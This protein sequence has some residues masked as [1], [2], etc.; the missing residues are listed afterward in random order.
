MWLKSAGVDQALRYWIEG[1]IAGAAGALATWAGAA[2]AFA[3][4]RRAAFAF[5]IVAAGALAGLLLA[6]SADIDI[7]AALFVP[8]QG[9]VAAVLGACLARFSDRTT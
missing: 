1:P 7:P 4:L 5:L 9:L 6:W 3:P 2:I 8:W